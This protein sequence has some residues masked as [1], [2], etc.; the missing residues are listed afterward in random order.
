VQPDTSL[1][2]RVF[3]QAINAGELELLDEL[4]APNRQGL[5]ARGMGLKQWIVNLRSAFPDVHC[6]IE[7]EIRMHDQFSARWTMRGTHQ[8]LL[9]GNRPTGKQMQAQGVFF[10]RLVDG[11]IGEY[12]LLVDQFGML[13]QLGIIP[14]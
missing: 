11:M 4:M 9:L 6:T 1:I 7:Q 8:G 5:P 2:Q 10:G 14:R 12:W 13:Q 3:D